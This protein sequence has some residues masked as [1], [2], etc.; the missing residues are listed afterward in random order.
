MLANMRAHV[1]ALH[2]IIAALASGQEDEAARIAEWQLGLSSLKSHGADKLG[3]H[4]PS[5]MRAFGREMHSA[6]SRFA[7]EAQTA[8]VTGDLR[9]AL[10]ALAE[11]TARCAA[12]HAAYRVR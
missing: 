4:M 9:P 5:A 1:G 11:V 7:L 6:A 2:K 8:G 3:K 12:C 10:A